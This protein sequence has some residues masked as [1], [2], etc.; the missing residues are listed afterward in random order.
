M[1]SCCDLVEVFSDQ[2]QYFLWITEIDDYSMSLTL[3][4]TNGS[5]IWK[6]LVSISDK[7]LSREQDTNDEF[8]Q[9]LKAAITDITYQSYEYLITF[10]GQKMLFLIKVLNYSYYGNEN[11]GVLYYLRKSWMTWVSYS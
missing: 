3:Q 5:G 11:Y 1:E 7:P 2:Q 6:G 4:I 9:M 8:F 10:H